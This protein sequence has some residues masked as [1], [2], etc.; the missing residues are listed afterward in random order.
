[1]GTTLQHIKC[2]FGKHTFIRKHQTLNNTHGKIQ[3]RECIV[4]GK[5]QTSSD[6]AHRV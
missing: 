1:M 5:F 6:S 3:Y 2:F 4:C